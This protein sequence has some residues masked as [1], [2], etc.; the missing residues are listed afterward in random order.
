MKKI[1]LIL[2]SCISL[3]GCTSNPYRENSIINQDINTLELENIKENEEPKLIEV[4]N[5]NAK[6]VIQ[7]QKDLGFILIATSEFEDKY[8][9][10]KNKCLEFAKELKAKLVILSIDYSKSETETWSRSFPE[11]VYTGA[12]GTSGLTSK[13]DFSGT[14]IGYNEKR[15]TYD[16]DKYNYKALYFIPLKNIKL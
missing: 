10:N 2:F 13:T 12:V 4:S 7:K 14:M 15:F 6:E 11:V 9:D 3:F 1:L 8:E 5:I 16:V